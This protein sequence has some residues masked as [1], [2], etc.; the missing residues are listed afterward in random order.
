MLAM[1]TMFLLFGK[2]T[3]GGQNEIV[4]LRDFKKLSL[5][6]SRWVYSRMSLR[7]CL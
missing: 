5:M 3:P 7:C 6:V 1:M 2:T 4:D